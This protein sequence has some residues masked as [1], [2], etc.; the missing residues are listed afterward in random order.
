MP[1]SV[2]ASIRSLKLPR[3]PMRKTL[4]A[5]L[6]RP[7]PSDMSKCSRIDGRRRSASWPSGMKNAVIELEYSRGSSQT[8]SSPHARTAARVASACR[9]CRRNTL[10]SPSSCSIRSA[11]RS[12]NSRFVAGV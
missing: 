12:P 1:L 10:A 8:I 6:R 4:P 7:V 3:W 5:S 11:S 2:P 9:S